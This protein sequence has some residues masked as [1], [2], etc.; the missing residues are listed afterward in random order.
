MTIRIIQLLA[1]E[2]WDAFSMRFTDQEKL[3]DGIYICE[4]FVL[5]VSYKSSK[6]STGFGVF[7]LHLITELVN[8]LKLFDLLSF[9][10]I[11][12]NLFTYIYSWLVVK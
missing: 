3:D 1:K 11:K 8:T 5:N 6:H 10:F 7:T 4:T 2:K 12:Q 9:H